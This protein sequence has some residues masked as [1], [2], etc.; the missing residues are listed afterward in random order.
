MKKII[1][2]NE[3]NLDMFL[4]RAKENKTQ[5][6]PEFQEKANKTETRDKKKS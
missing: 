1:Y 6:Q 5:K 4:K 2:W 3:Q